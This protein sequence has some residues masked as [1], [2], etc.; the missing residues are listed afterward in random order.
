MKQNHYLL[1]LFFFLLA[2]VNKTKAQY[3]SSFRNITYIDGFPQNTIQALCKDQKG[4]L[5][6]GTESGLSRY[7][8]KRITNYKIGRNSNFSLTGKTISHITC[9]TSG[10]LWVSSDLGLTLFSP[11]A[12]PE[13]NKKLEAIQDRINSIYP[14]TELE[15]VKVMHNGEVLLGYRT[16]LILYNTLTGHFRQL[17]DTVYNGKKLSPYIVNI[18]EL[19]TK[20]L[21]VTTSADGVFILNRFYN[22]IARIAPGSFN[23][24]RTA[25][26]FSTVVLPDRHLF[27][28]SDEGI[29]KIADYRNPRP[30]KITATGITGLTGQ[31][32]CLSYDAHRG[33]VLAGSNLSGVMTFD[34][35]GLLL[36]HFMDSGTAGRLRSNNIYYLLTDENNLGYWI[37]TGKGLL[38][39]FYAENKINAFAV[40]DNFES[41]LR[42]YPIYTEDNKRLLVGTERLLLQYDFPGGKPRPVPVENNAD[43]RYNY[44]LKAAPGLY[45]FC[46]RQ[47]LYYSESA[48]NPRLRKISRKFPELA[49]LDTVIVLCGVKM[50]D[51]EILFGLRSSVAGDLVRW[52]RSER[53]AERFVHHQRMSSMD[54]YTVNFLAPA[55]NDRFYICTNGGLYLFDNRE[56]TCSPFLLPVKDKLNYP[57]VN[58]VLPDNGI[59]WIGTYGGG[60]NK[61]N[62]KEH[63]IEYITEKEGLAN[64]DIYAVLKGDSDHIWLSSNGGLISY[65]IRNGHIRNYDKADGVINI[66]FNRTSFCKHNDTLYFG[67]ISG[68]NYFD[69]RTV[70]FS[71]LRPV[72]DISGISILTRGG[73]IP[74]FPDKNGMINTSYSANTFKLYLASPFYINPLKTT[75]SHRFHSSGEEWI[76]D[77]TNNEIIL[78]QLPPGRHTVEIK[79]VS[80]EGIESSNS[81]QVLIIVSPPWYQTTIFRLLLGFIIAGVLY[82]F[83]RMRLNQLTK[84]QRIRNQ[85]ASD[86]HDDL[87]STLNSIKVHSNLAQLE[88]DKPEHLQHVKQGAQDAISGVRDII[89]VLDD[90]KDKVTDMLARVAQFAVPLCH[91]NNIRYIVSIGEDT[92]EMT[93]GKE[94]KRNLYM[95]I[96]EFINNSIKYAECQTITVQLSRTGKKITLTVSDDGRGFDTAT[97]PAGNGLKNMATRAAA[98]HYSHSIVSAPGKGTSITLEKK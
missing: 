24:N 78:T 91:S 43:L 76:F 29:F 64:N 21:V 66:E 68:I 14:D 25:I 28:A 6:I 22:I 16:S 4:Y 27:I 44:I 20:E 17:L 71:S 84:E 80:S 37:G 61:Y 83:Y 53:T 52:N 93:L 41:P 57:Q 23:N 45:L 72:A 63:T 75:F 92:G 85:F 62:L 8:G 9:D 70:E 32:N 55:G 90:K 56:R 1:L 82:L 98:I 18:Y 94:E 81:K 11:D 31:F 69:C 59:L 79:S 38:K 30:V 51:N 48:E 95:I 86:L 88:K 19:D 54:D 13:F 65:N 67:G 47:G 74:V 40:T 12:A 58:A 50:N 42:S 26:L 10:N 73:E 46:T 49:L 5:W 3:P 97:A 36:D 15:T 87:G 39:L 33:L 35:T 96:K 77:G 2:L 89:W 60:L 7:D 34:S